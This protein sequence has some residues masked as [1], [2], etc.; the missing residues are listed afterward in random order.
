MTSISPTA[1]PFLDPAIRD[2]VTPEMIAQLKANP[3]IPAGIIKA[4]EE[5]LVAKLE[6]PCHRRLKDFI[7]CDKD[8]I[9]IKDCIEKVAETDAPVLLIGETGTGKEILASSLHNTRTGLFVPVNCAGLPEGLIESE[10]FGHTVGAFTGANKDKKGMLEEANNGTI[11]L[12]EIGELPLHTQG[13]LLRAVQ[14]HKIRRVGDNK[15]LSVNCRFVFATN[16][17]LHS[18]A[19]EGKFRMDLYYRISVIELFIKPLRDRVEDI[20]LL[21]T[22]LDRENKIKNKYEWRHKL[23]D[24]DHHYLDGNVRSLQNYVLRYYLLGKEPV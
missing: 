13:K 6:T 20:D 4:Y 19:K 17:D 5:A 12:D 23:T 10:L 9:H 18:L 7:T 16:R 3:S 8:T 15:E 14:E 1:N 24:P 21:L 11:F 2:R 22:H